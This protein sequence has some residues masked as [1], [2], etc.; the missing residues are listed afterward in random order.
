MQKEQ[1]KL[2]LVAVVLWIV[3]TIL[4]VL[5]GL[6]LVRMALGHTT[7]IMRW[8]QVGAMALV[9]LILLAL[10]SILDRLSQIVFYLQNLQCGHSG[11]HAVASRNPNSAASTIGSHLLLEAS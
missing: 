10:G 7:S 3:A 9:A 8:L 6:H 2:T 4:L 11:L 5:F 1:H